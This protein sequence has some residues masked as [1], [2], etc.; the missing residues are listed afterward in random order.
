MK[1]RQEYQEKA[2]KFK[3]DLDYQLNIEQ[4]L[5]NKT[6]ELETVIS[7]AKTKKDTLK[8]RARSAEASKIVY[9]YILKN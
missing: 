3:K 9:L 1:R 7:D 5:I 8:A 6:K 4:D 2:D